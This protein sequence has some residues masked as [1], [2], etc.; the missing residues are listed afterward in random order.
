MKNSA[1]DLWL[2]SNSNL[3]KNEENYFCRKWNDNLPE[4]SESEK[5]GL[6]EI[7]N[8]FIFLIENQITEELVK[9]IVLSPLLLIADFYSSYFQ[10]RQEKSV[11][12]AIQN[13]QK[14]VRSRIDSFVIQ[15]QLWIAVLESKKSGC[16]LQSAIFQ[17]LTHI[18]KTPIPELPA[19]GFITNGSEF[20]FIKSL[21]Q[22]TPKHLFSDLLSIHNQENEL[23]TVARILK[24]ISDL[25][26]TKN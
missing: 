5:Q 20:V 15:N 8:N 16:S 19:Y 9:P 3:E 21:I 13:N 7:K 24:Q 1:L 10:I 17:L 25:I 11:S 14:L 22:P 12:I 18:L 23:Y 6:D 2:T 26:K 4:L